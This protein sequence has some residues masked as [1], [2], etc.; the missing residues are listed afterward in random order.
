MNGKILGERGRG[1]FEAVCWLP[2]GNEH[3]H[4]TTR[5][6]HWTT[7]TIKR[8]QAAHSS[9]L[10]IVSCTC[11]RGC[12][13]VGSPAGQRG[14]QQCRHLQ[15]AG[16]RRVTEQ[17]ALSTVQYWAILH[18]ALSSTGR[19]CTEHCPVLGDTAL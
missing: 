2:R 18:W 10:R 13:P 19:Y 17:G 16:A 7:R 6:G 15:N 3:N 11:A 5:L 1:Q 14:T 4:E 9:W 12:D 8:E